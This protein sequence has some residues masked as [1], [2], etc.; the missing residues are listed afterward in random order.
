M[1]FDAIRAPGATGQIGSR[2]ERETPGRGKQLDIWKP[3]VAALL[4]ATG[5]HA[6]L[7][8]MRD[9]RGRDNLQLRR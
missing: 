8:S 4:F 9:R 6:C 2:E 5:V 3:S 1:A 7:L